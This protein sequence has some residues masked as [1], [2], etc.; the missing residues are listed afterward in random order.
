MKIHLQSVPIKKHPKRQK[1]EQRNDDIFMR[2]NQYLAPCQ[3]TKRY[4]GLFYRGFPKQT[5]NFFIGP[6]NMYHHLWTS[7]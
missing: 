5:I 1:T 3:A 7:K 4:N 2:A 6:W